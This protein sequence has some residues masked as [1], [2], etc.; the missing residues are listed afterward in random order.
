MEEL[1]IKQGF[2]CKKMKILVETIY[3]VRLKMYNNSVL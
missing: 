2:L 3:F 1:V